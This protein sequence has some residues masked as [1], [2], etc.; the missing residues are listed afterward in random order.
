M[1]EVGAW[2]VDMKGGLKLVEGGWEEYAT[3][4]YGTS[5]FLVHVRCLYLYI[6]RSGPTSR[7]RFFIYQYRYVGAYIGTSKP[8]S[9]R[10][11]MRLT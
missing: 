9:V 1:M 7:Y 11:S 5:L 3:M 2:R 10:F 6:F 4:V 8:P